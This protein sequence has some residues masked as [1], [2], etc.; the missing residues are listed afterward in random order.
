MSINPVDWADA[1][2]P[3]PCASVSGL[4]T[5]LG[6]GQPDRDLPSTSMPDFLQKFKLTGGD[7]HGDEGPLHIP[8]V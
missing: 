3:E 6:V 5:G 2:D 7:L 4:L 8:I 1:P